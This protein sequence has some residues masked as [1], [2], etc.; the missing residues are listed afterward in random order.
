[1][2]P[3]RSREFVMLTLHA[4]F[5]L[6]YLRRRWF[7]ALLIVL[8]IAAGVS[9]LVATT[10]LNDTMARAA[11]AAANPIVGSVDLIVSNG[12]APVDRA[13]AAE[14]KK[15][16][17]EV[18]GAHPRIFERVELSEFDK[19]SVSLIGLDFLAEVRK[20]DKPNAEIEVAWNRGWG[21]LVARK[22]ALVGKALAEGLPSA[23]TIS[24][25]APGQAKPYLLP[26]AGVID[27]RGVAAAL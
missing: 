22:G 12:D 21:P 26:C 24:V 27:A 15:E 10:A 13:L 1:M 16:I 6:R 9:L 18:A 2:P 11:Q 19:R 8:S 3:D 17:A 4:T 20:A 5:S 25:R 23:E 7:R 14:I